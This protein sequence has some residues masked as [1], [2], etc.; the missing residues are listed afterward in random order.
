MGQPEIVERIK[1]PEVPRENRWAE[2]D[3]R[4]A[5]WQMA[6]PDSTEFEYCQACHQIEK[7]LGL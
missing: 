3:R 1:A 4:K 6:N 2:Y 5:L 7:D